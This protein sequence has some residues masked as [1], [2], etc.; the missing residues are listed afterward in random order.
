[1]RRLLRAITSRI[2]NRTPDDSSAQATG[3]SDP[4]TLKGD[5]NVEW[6]YVAARIGR[7]SGPGDAILDFG[8]GSGILSLAAG[9]LGA[10]VL[11]VDLMPRQFDLTYPNIEFRQADIMDLDESRERFDLILNCSTVEHVGLSGRYGAVESPDGDLAAMRKLRGL[12]KPE[13]VMVFTLPVGADAVF[14][15]L[16]R[17]YGP[18]RLPRLIEGYRIVESQFLRKKDED[19]WTPCEKADALSEIG[20]ERYYALGFMALKKS[21]SI[22]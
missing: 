2:R 22:D 13:G 18:E 16:H 5:R 8:C 3:V 19:V 21:G 4:R 20:S 17:I 10:R 6:S 1:M 14:K 7:Y 12:M 9:S 11:A 15:P